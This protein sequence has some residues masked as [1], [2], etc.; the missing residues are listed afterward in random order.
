MPLAVG[1]QDRTVHVTLRACSELHILLDQ[2]KEDV[3]NASSPDIDRYT[4][5]RTCSGA[6]ALCWGHHCT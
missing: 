3:L 4:R 2:M 1:L 5:L 6:A